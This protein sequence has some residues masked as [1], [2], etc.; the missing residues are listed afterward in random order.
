MDTPSASVLILF[1][2]AILA[3]LSKLKLPTKIPH[4]S[5]EKISVGSTVSKKGYEEVV[6]R[7]LSEI[8]FQIPDLEFDTK[9]KVRVEDSLESHG[10]SRRFIAKVEPCISTATKITSFS[11]PFASAEVQ[12]AI[13]LYAAYVIS[14]DDT[15]EEMTS[16]LES[17]GTELV[18]GQTHRHELLRGFTSLL[19][20]QQRLFGKFGG[21]MVIKNSIEF[22]SSVIIEQRQNG[23]RLSHDTSDYLDYFRIKTGVA[24]SFAFFCFPENINPEN[25][26]LAKYITAI[27]SINSFL[28]YVNDMLSFYKEELEEGDCPGYIES[29]AKVHGTTL[30]QSLDQLRVKTVDEIRKIR[31]ILSDDAIMLE[32][33]NQFIHGYIF[34]H[35]CASRYRLNELNIPIALEAKSRFREMLKVRTQ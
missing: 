20:N 13:A 10:V 19:S 35:L 28:G 25:Q 22:I 30:L 4:L 29:H 16:H 6:N 9:L 11:Y 31:S 18:L 3:T 1:L 5:S 21:D 24:E 2:A 23:L 32:R 27:P 7:F 33:I 8:S 17:Y 15:L 12:E 26:D 34:Y 14:I